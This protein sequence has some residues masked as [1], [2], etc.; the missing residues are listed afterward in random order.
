MIALAGT[1]QQ[2]AAIHVYQDLRLRLDHELGV[3]PGKALVEA[4]LR[5]LH[6]DIPAAVSGPARVYRSS[7]AA[8][9]YLVPRQLPAAPRHF[10]GRADELSTLSSL[11]D[12][13]QRADAVV[14]AA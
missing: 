14:I 7:S 1:G 12:P 4:H 10:T 9:E 13:V 3:Y 2:A 8:A 11:L 6:Q 5:V